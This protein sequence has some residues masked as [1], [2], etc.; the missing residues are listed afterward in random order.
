MFFISAGYNQQ[1]QQQQPHQQQQSHRNYNRPSTSAMY[2]SQLSSNSSM[3]S[4]M[5]S[6]IS[7]STQNT[8]RARRRG[9][10]DTDPNANI[11]RLNIR[12]NCCTIVLLHED[13]LV[14]CSVFEPE[15]PITED[16]VNR[17]KTMSENYFSSISTVNFGR[18]HDDLIAAGKKLKIATGQYNH[19]R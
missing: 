9:I 16:S 4:S 2:D 11:S 3:T 15:C 6:S 10:I 1:Q 13:V 14:E 5:C 7:Q 12:I 8:S 17:L 19:L 18:N